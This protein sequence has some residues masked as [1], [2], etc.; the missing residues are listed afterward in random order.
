MSSLGPQL[1]ISGIATGIDTSSLIDKIIAFESQ[2]LNLLNSQINALK[3]QENAWNPLRGLFQALHDAADALTGDTA[4]DPQ[5]VAVSDTTV[6]D[7]TAGDGATAGTYTI[8]A[9]Q[10]YLAQQ[11]IT[12]PMARAEQDVSTT[13]SITDPNAALGYTGTF[14]LNGTTFTL[15]GSE[16]LNQIAAIINDQTATTH[17]KASVLQVYDSTTGTTHMALQLLSTK[18]GAAN[19]ITYGDQTSSTTGGV[20]LFV[21]LGILAS[22]TDT[23]AQASAV[24]QRAQDAHFVI[25]GVAMVSDSNTITGA[26][27]GVTITLKNLKQNDQVT[28]TLTPDE[29]AVERNVQKFVDAFNNLVKTIRDDTKYDPQTK[30]GGPLLG[31]MD[32][33]LGQNRLSDDVQAWVSAAGTF[34][35]LAQ[36]GITQSVDG[37]LQFDTAKFRDAWNQDPASVK[38]LFGAAGTGVAARIADD[39]DAWL[40]TGGILDAATKSW[41]DRIK[42]LQDRADSMREF[43]QRREQMLRDQFNRMEEAISRLQSQA[44]SLGMALNALFM[45]QS[46]QSNG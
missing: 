22:T 45:Q 38:A 43:L 3:Q 12:D 15:D 29:S 21:D 27:P 4:W 30:Q 17:V 46:G 19:A 31:N 16:G 25:N 40:K 20:S 26:I 36:I 34:Q 39:T 35:T 2:P 18:T 33:L 42:A 9:D 41:D 11:G 32:L 7:A 13:A 5:Q 1:G 28:L 6:L 37:T 44:Q 23:S 14:T 24:K 10:A 8:Q